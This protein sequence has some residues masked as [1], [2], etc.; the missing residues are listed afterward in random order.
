MHRDRPPAATRRRTRRGRRPRHGRRRLRHA[1]GPRGRRPGQ[2][3]R[4]ARLGR[5]RLPPRRARPVA[6]RELAGRD[7]RLGPD[8][9]LQV[10][11]DYVEVL[12]TAV[13]AALADA[14]VDPAQVVGIATDFTACTM[15]PDHRRRHPAVRAARATPPSR[16]P[17]SS[18]GSTTPPSRRPTG[19]NE[20]ARKRGE[21]W[22]PRYGGL[23][24]SEWEFAKGLQL[25]EE[26]PAVYADDG[27]LGRGRR[28]DRLAAVRH[29]TS[30]TPAPPA[31]RA[32][33]RTAPTRRRDFLAELNPDF[34]DFVADKLDAPDRPA[35]RRPPAG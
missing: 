10:P 11:A 5:L 14:G 9:A 8:W 6:A 12:R 4:G 25:L 7:V 30:A 33:T 27:A 19:I 29:A 28:L 13:P 22:L 34:A 18:S 23:I 17:T 31:T 16:T 35:R 15:V 26:A 3:R 32:S 21:A 1:L 2:R 24:S 20:L